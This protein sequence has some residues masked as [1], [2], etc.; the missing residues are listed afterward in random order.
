MKQAVQIRKTRIT[1][2]MRMLAI[3]AG[4]VALA[5]TI[6]AAAQAPGQPGSALTEQL[7][8]RVNGSVCTISAL[9]ADGSYVSRGSGFVL[10]DSGHLVTNAHV[11]AGLQ[12]ARAKCGGREF[13]L[14]RVV[15]FDRNIDLA[16]ADIGSV[17][18][19][20]LR[21]D[22]DR[23]VKPGA[24]VYVFGSP[25]GLEGTM[26][27]G[28]ASGQRVLDGRS[29]IQISAPIDAGSSG[30]P[31]T[32]ATGAVIGVVVASLEVAQSINFAIPAAAL[33]EL[34]DVDLQ[35]ADLARERAGVTTAPAVKGPSLPMRDSVATGTAAFRGN[36]FG[37]PC[38]DIAVAEYERQGTGWGGGGA[39][40][41]DKHY[42]GTLELDVDLLGTPATVYYDCD[43]RFGM[44]AGH[45]RINGH[46]DGVDTIASILRSKYGTGVTRTVTE[47]EAGARG[48]SFNYTLPA[49]RFHRPSELKSWRVDDRFHIDMLVCG[50]RSKTTFLFYRDPLLVAS[51][52]TG[53]G[54]AAEAM[55]YREGDL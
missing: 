39:I 6:A 21:L 2:L 45:Y 46:T 25:F 16:V 47:D 33:A 4:I 3:T 51:A 14:R 12:Q 55:T 15:K 5:A 52:D 30:G 34:P 11:V 53:Q 23:N 40:R 24:P 37:S 36:V 18:I 1:I 35:T 43:S 10:S 44:T 49:S 38:G 26:T 13:D 32:D 31:V 20:G 42:S 54:P 28:L 29:Y 50:G 9:A 19:P 7:F 8:D 27:P 48:C 17:D 22:S 41:F